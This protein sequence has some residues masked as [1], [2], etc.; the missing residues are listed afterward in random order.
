LNR[1]A[2]RG[3]TTVALMPLRPAA[4]ETAAA[5]LPEEWVA[6][7]RDASA[8]G[9]R[10]DGVGRPA[11]LEGPGLLEVLALEEEMRAGELVQ[12]GAR[13]DGGAPDPVADPRMRLVDVS[14]EDFVHLVGRP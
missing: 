6:T 4:Q 1:L 14:D 5:W 11:G 13:E 3:M 12:P 9:E 8:L 10:E 7:P 2:V